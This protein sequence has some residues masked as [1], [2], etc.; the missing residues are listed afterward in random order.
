MEDKIMAD[1]D[2]VSR[3]EKQ[4]EGSN[5]ALAAVAEVLHK[6]DSRLSKAEEEELEL[7]QEQE[8][9][10]E[11]QEIIKAVA[12]EVF[13][14]IKA[15]AGNPTKAQW[16]SSTEVSAKSMTG[17]GQADDK[18]NAVTINSKTE[19][20]NR[21]IQAMQL[22]LQLLKES[23]EEEGYDVE[24]EGFG[25]AKQPPEDSEED[26]EY[27]ENEDDEEEEEDD[28]EVQESADIQNM[29][30]QIANLQKS[31]SKKKGNVQKLIENET[32][33]RLRKM[34]FSEENGLNR[35]QLIKYDDNSLGIDGSQPIKKARDGE[36]VVDQMMSL[37][38]GDLRRLQEQINSGETDGV[39]RELL[40]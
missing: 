27:P 25:M 35:P 1:S 8:D 30:K 2:M 40:G 10:F 21:T 16:G 11:K 22:Q 18:E 31:V 5:L 36:E 37:S 15:D 20:A 17:T 14:L 3:L 12:G 32:E 19:D 26:E 13:G 4:I 6:M 39:P 23:L 34:G 7:S 28:E 29:A 33:K 24:K 9:E 38:Y